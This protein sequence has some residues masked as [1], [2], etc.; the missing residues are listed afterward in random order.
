MPLFLNE[1]D[2]GQ[3]LTMPLAIEA[4]EEAHR[5]LSLGQAIDIPRQRTRLPQTTL[6]ILQ[7]AL[8]GRNAIGYTAYTSNRSGIRFVVHLFNASTGAL[9]VVLEADLLGMMRTGAAS[10]VATRW[11]ARPDA[12]IL[13]VFGCG[14]QAEGHIE[15]IAAVRSL[16]RVKVYAR[17]AER[18]AVFCAKMSERLGIEVVAASSAE[19]TVRGSDIVGTVTTSATPLL[20]ANWLSPGT[21]INAAGSNSLI[22]RE[23]GE[24]VLKVSRLLVVDS[25]ETALKEAGDLLPALEKG[26]LNERQLV[27]LGD[28]IVGRH[29]G[30]KTPGE[31]TLFESQGMVIQDLSLAV[32]IEA[33]ARERGLGTE[34]PYGG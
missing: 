30:R 12:E 11:L 34:L 20:D 15:A 22:R 8:P 29:P 14:W 25:V 6:H 5:E 17:N 10:G 19:E 4:V 21:H 33:L 1:S 32:R 27:E 18:L 31:I 9:R 24:D 7:G 3:L 23:V 2:V 28:V 26:R 16:R 13:G